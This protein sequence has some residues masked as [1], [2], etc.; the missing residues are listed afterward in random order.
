MTVDVRPD[1]AINEEW[2]LQAFQALSVL[3]TQTLCQLPRNHALLC[4]ALNHSLTVA[5]YCTLLGNNLSSKNS[6]A[7]GEPMQIS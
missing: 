3:F 4:E 5:L 1:S 7:M 6:T 2:P